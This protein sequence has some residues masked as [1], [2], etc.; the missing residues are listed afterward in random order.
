MQQMWV[1]RDARNAVKRYE[2]TSEYLLPFKQRHL[3]RKA[4]SLPDAA[5]SKSGDLGILGHD[6]KSQLRRAYREL[7]ANS[8]FYPEESEKPPPIMP[9]RR[10]NFER[11][12]SPTEQ[13]SKW[14]RK[15]KEYILLRRDELTELTSL[16]R[17]L[18]SERRN[19]QRQCSWIFN[20]QQLSARVPM[21][22]AKMAVT[23]V[24]KAEMREAR[25]LLKVV[26]GVDGGKDGWKERKKMKSK[27]GVS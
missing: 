8:M 18:R 23:D 13:E 21:P 10:N 17:L 20:D 16:E 26:I 6:K 9:T 1:A 5:F 24:C 2:E 11:A 15:S 25:S 27:V 19:L 7:H 14:E 3:D 22:V 12:R 4:V